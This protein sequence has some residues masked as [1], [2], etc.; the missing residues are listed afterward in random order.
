VTGGC[1]GA[2]VG[3]WNGV[4]IPATIAAKNHGLGLQILN[5]EAKSVKLN[6][7]VIIAS[8]LSNR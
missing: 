7:T 6:G 4:E 1:G 3:G 8:K 5:R 2:G